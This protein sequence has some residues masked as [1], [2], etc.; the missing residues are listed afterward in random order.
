MSSVHFEA[1]YFTIYILLRYLQDGSPSG[2]YQS[3]GVANGSGSIH[4]EGSI[5]QSRSRSRSRSREH[6]RWGNPFY[7][8]FQIEPYLLNK[9]NLQYLNT[10]PTKP[11]LWM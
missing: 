4:E 7:L 11:E 1:L 2:S 5:R 9:S 6:D 8:P 3:E 10:G